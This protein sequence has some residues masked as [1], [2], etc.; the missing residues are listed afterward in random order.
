[1]SKF[2]FLELLRSVNG[3]RTLGTRDEVLE[4]RL[5]SIES[6]L[7]NVTNNDAIKTEVT[8][9]NVELE[10]NAKLGR[11]DELITNQR[12]I[13][14]VLNSDKLMFGALWDKSSDSTLTRTD[15]AVGLIAEVGVDGEY[16]RNDFDRMPIWGEAEDVMDEYGNYFV[17]IPKFYI[18]KIVGKDF[19]LTQVSK[20]R[21]PGFYLPWVFWDFENNKELDYYDHAKYKASI[22][23]DGTRLESKPDKYPLVNT[24]IAQFRNY[25]EANNNE[26]SG[27]T[28]YQQM[29]LHAHD[30]LTT[31]FTVEFATIHSQSVMQGFVSGAYNDSHTATLA[32]ED[33]NRIVVS[34]SAANAFS[35]GQTIVVG[36]VRINSNIMSDRTLLEI[37]DVDDN[38]KELVFDGEPA[39]ISVGDVVASR[40]WKTG[41]SRDILASSGS[42]GSNTSGRYPCHYR[43]I[44][45][46]WGDV[47]E[48]VDGININD[49]QT[50]VTKDA[51]DYASN[52]FAF[53][54]E[55]VGYVNINQNV[56]VTEMG[57]DSNY[58]FAELPIKGGGGTS[59][60][61]ADH[62]YQNPGQR[63]AR[64]GGYF[65]FGAHAGLR[66][67]SSSAS[68]S[69]TS[70]LLSGRLLKKAS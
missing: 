35:V 22:S 17:R 45:S 47:Y 13:I 68:S 62:Y 57:Y 53:P 61:Y 12:E 50:W 60:Y 24:N 65:S 41:F 64:V 29:D 39:N 10:V 21:Y 37:N 11:I 31:L 25:A 34:S 19:H 42:I 70:L 6:K 1:M 63:I 20:T 2:N 67:W 66:L 7:D 43:G 44:E 69:S 15:A 33:T 55:Q 51:K 30:V 56:W 3:N 8:G 38:N 59:T 46:P 58:P 9:S 52:V 40:G 4:E 14:N 23:D 27:V 26:S 28:G 16:V 32:E 5:N 49:H 54:Y 48:F 36:T 18:K